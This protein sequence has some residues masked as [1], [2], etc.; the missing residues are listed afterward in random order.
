MQ[1]FKIYTKHIC[2]FF[3]TFR[4]KNAFG[5]ATHGKQLGHRVDHVFACHASAHFQSQALTGVLVHNRQPLQ[6]A[7]AGGVIENEIPCPYMVLVL[8]SSAM[9]AVLTGSQT[10]A[11]PAF[12]WHFQPFPTPQ[13]IHTCFACPQS[14]ATKKSSDPVI[15]KSVRPLINSSIRFT[16]L[17]SSS[18]GLHS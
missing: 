12:L 10:P 6:L 9:A 2:V 3:N 13:A 14:L 4:P 1:A 11:F 7:P 8:C 16:S 15:T 18:R 17:D 5:D